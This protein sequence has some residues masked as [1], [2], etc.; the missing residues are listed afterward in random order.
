MV[1]STC[2]GGAT[3]RSVF[4]RELHR[5]DDEHT[6]AYRAARRRYHDAV[7]RLI[8]QGQ[9][10]GLFAAVASADIV[11]FTIFGMIINELPLCYRLS[12]RSSGRF[13]SAMNWLIL[14][15][16]DSMPI[17]AW[18]PTDTKEL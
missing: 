2:R 14:S 7:C 13:R 4:W 18:K 16:P 12:G 1:E 9:A 10:A 6:S 15:S 11:T 8:K 3:Q 5:L 17:Q